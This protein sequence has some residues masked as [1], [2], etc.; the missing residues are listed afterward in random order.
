MIR[1][2]IGGLMHESN[3]FAGG[4]TDR[5]AF[6]VGGLETGDGIFARWGSAH[7]EVA[8]FF[9]A[10]RA[11]GFEVVPTLMG[12]ATPAGPLTRDCYRELTEALI[13]SI[14]EAGTVDAVVLALHG[15]MLAEGESDADG[16]IL[17]R[18]RDRIGPQGIFVATLDYHGNVSE[19][20]AA[21]TDALVGYRTYPHVDQRARGRHAAQL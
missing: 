3:T 2:A 12:W 5:S 7:H 9:D 10:A 15:A 8:G 19:R 4:E 18:V 13:R 17:S 14:D 16:T 1:I 20:M 21:A 11:D 6:E